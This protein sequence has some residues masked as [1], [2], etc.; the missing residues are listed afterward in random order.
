MKLFLNRT[1]YYSKIKKQEDDTNKR[2][3][4]LITDESHIIKLYNASDLSTFLHEVCTFI[5]RNGR[6]A[7]RKA[8]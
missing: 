2:G 5:F 3:S 4:I 6:Q 8:R 7:I 1:N